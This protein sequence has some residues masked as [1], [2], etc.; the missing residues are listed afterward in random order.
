MTVASLFTLSATPITTPSKTAPV[1]IRDQLAITC[2]VTGN[3][4]KWN[5][6][7]SGDES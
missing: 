1:C 7:L 6:N 3:F 2:N 5:I 4:L